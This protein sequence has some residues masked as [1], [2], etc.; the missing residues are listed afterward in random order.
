MNKLDLQ[1]R[2]CVITGGSG[3]IGFAIAERFAASGAKVVLWDINIDAA[4]AAAERLRAPLASKVDVTDAT[5]VAAAAAE[6]HSR[7]G[8]IDVLINAAGINGPIGP[9]ESY[10]VDG[11][12][13]VIEINLTGV[14]ICC[15][16][17]V[18]YL[19]NAN[20]GRIVNLSS[21]GGKEGNPNQGAY[22]ASK[23]GVIA[24]TKSLGKELADTEIRVNCVTPAAIESEMLQKMTAEQRSF[25]LA[26]IPLG[27][28]GR[29]DEVASMVA[30]LSTEECSF[31]TGAAFDL[32]GGRA[33]Y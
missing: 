18:P 25:V 12:R 2:V 4:Q 3:G 21:V 1:D 17:T 27:R 5:S 16:E 13:R 11:W 7:F 20:H 23:A 24:L 28:A 29:P 33:T 10:P 15:R 26:K 22:G 31:S 32:T 19:R 30:W 9:V 14:F 8:S 6:A